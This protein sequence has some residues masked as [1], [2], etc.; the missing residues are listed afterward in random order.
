MQRQVMSGLVIASVLA[1]CVFSLGARHTD[2]SG[3][4]KWE[5]KLLP[6]LQIGIATER[7]NRDTNNPIDFSNT[8]NASMDA[9][10][11]SLGKEG[12]ELVCIEKG[13]ACFKRP[14]R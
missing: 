7:A 10:F 13:T 11:N 1:L 3:T 2:E 9:E 4:C 6:L 14:N 5:Y 12:W 8:V